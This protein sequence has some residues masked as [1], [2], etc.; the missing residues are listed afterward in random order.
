MGQISD[1]LALNVNISKTVGDTSKLMTNR[2]SHIQGSFPGK[3]TVGTPGGNVPLPYR[4]RGWG[5]DTAS[6]PINFFDFGS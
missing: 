3:R 4:V 5:G 6:L 2:K 1:F